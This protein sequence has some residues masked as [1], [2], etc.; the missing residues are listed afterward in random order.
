MTS[1]AKK[2]FSVVLEKKCE[3]NK[4]L[5]TIKYSLDNINNGVYVCDCTCNKNLINLS[6]NSFDLSFTVG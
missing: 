5:L 6:N 2:S 1:Y 4:S 3:H